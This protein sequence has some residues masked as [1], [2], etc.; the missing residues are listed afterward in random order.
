MRDKNREMQFWFR[1]LNTV[2]L[3]NLSPQSGEFSFDDWWARAAAVVD[4]QVGQGLN[5]IIILRAWSIWNHQNQCV[6]DGASHL[7]QILQAL[8]LHPPK[9]K[10]FGGGGGGGGGGGPKRIFSKG[11]MRRGANTF[12]WGFFLLSR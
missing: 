4:G 5:S 2:G 8:W 11:P 10:D 3:Q 7:H 1:L 6:F 12:A 9:K